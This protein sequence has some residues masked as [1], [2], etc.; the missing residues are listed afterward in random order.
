MPGLGIRGSGSGAR[1]PRGVWPSFGSQ[2]PSPEPRAP[3]SRVPSPESR[4]GIR[5][6][7][8]TSMDPQV[9]HHDESIGGL[10][11]GILTDLR[12]LIREEIALARVE[13]REQ[14]GK[15]RAAAMSF[16]IAAAALLFGGT[17]LLVALATG[18]AE[19]LDL[20]VWVGFLIVAV[21]L[22][23]IGLVMLSSGRRQM[24]TFHA[25]PEETVSTLKENSEWIAKRLSSA[26]K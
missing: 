23:A 26:Q 3:E 19:L 6:A 25:V 8:A 14:A 13:I 4:V 1:D 9:V 21:L 18:I 22:S 2:F 11:R 20:P 10:V 16:G 24:R 17:F 12:T 7:A 15:A 5:L